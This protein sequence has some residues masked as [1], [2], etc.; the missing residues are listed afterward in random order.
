KLV[1]PGDV[2]LA[3]GI[4]FPRVRLG[5][6][7]GRV[8]I[9]KS[10]ATFDQFRVKSPDAEAALEGDIELR[11]PFQA[12]EL[13]LYLRFKPSADLSEREPTFE[14]LVNGM[15]AGKRTDG[16]LGFAILGTVATPIS[17]PSKDPPTGVSVRSSPLGMASAPSAPAIDGTSPRRPPTPMP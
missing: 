10:R 16:F 8:V 5:K 13:H 14:L 11:D 6:I 2:F 7:S 12:S 15:A 4:T 17:R 9:A 1:V 3:A